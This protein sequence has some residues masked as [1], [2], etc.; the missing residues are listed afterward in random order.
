MKKWAKDWGCRMKLTLKRIVNVARRV[1][2][3]LK[4]D[5]RFVG[6]SIV[7]PLVIIYFMNIVF[8]ALASPMFDV[9]IYVIP[10]GGFI[11]HFITFILTAIVLVRERVSGTLSRMFVSGYN[12]V[13]II[14][15]YII[16]YSTLATVQSLTVLLEL[17]WLFELE[18]SFEKL[19]SLY[20]VMW[21]LSIASV[22]LGT[23][24]SNFA[25][26]EGQVFPFIPLVI[27]SAIL[28]GIILPV[29][30]LPEWSQVLSYFTPLYYSNEI[31][32]EL[33]KDVKLIDSLGLIIS[34]VLYVAVTISMAMTTLRE[35]D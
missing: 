15:G 2:L 27:L 17:N 25:R 11:I 9:K 1:L 32:Q 19:I 13:E 29:E 21:L 30:Q 16:A 3:Q 23:L 35:K 12:Q 7:I 4:G 31:I 24:V 34:L 33:L 28:S 6:A 8:D 18:F 10:Y 5:R 20:L 22:A 26:N 14:S